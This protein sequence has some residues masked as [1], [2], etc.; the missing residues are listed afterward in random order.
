MSKNNHPGNAGQQTETVRIK[1]LLS[2]SDRQYETFKMRCGRAFLQNVLHKYPFLIDAIIERQSY[3]NWWEKQFAQGD[4][5]FL[6]AADLDQINTQILGAMYA[7]LHNPYTLPAELL[8]GVVFEG[9]PF[10]QKP[11]I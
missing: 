5:I 7:A 1:Q 3:W 9:M 4:H 6:N 2:I 10:T 8:N 11:A